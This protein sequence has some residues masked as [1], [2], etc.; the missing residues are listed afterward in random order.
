MSVRFTAQEVRNI[1]S[2]LERSAPALEVLGT[3]DDVYV[4]RDLGDK[5]FEIYGVPEPEDHDPLYVLD[6]ED[7]AEFGFFNRYYMLRDD[8]FDFDGNDDPTDVPGVG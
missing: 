8:D 2:G 6:A 4:N 5:R 3:S 7:E 1:L